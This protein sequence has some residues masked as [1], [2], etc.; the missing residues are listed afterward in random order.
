MNFEIFIAKRIISSKSGGKSGAQAL[1]NISVAAI[2]LSLSVMII[3]ISVLTGFKREIKEKLSGFGS[4]IQISNLD[5]NNSYE[6]EP[7][8]RSDE[9]V[10]KI[11]QL[12][13]VINIHAF[14]TKPGIIKSGKE[15]QGIVLKGVEDLA[16]LEFYASNLVA[17]RL[18]RL[19][20]PDSL[21]VLVSQSLA[22]LLRLEPGMKLP[23]YFVQEPLRM[24]PF[25]ISGIYNTGLEEYDRLFVLCHQAH[26]QEINNWTENQVSGYEIRIKK[27][28]QADRTAQTIQEIADG[29]TIKAENLVQVR[30]IRQLAPGFFDFL[31]LTDTNVWVILTLMTLIAGFNMVSGLLIIILD[32]VRMIGTL[33][34]LGTNNQS[35][36]KIFLYQAAYITGKGMLI[37][38]IIGIGIALL[39]M[40]L[41]VIPLD[42]ESYFVNSVPIFINPLHIILINLG[43]MLLTILMLLIPSGMISRISPDK[44]LKFD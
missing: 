20:Q 17:G 14:S 28:L 42:P 12:N 26:I 18:P 3:A 25:I 16:S 21:D 22:N 15:L 6:T 44:T 23:T 2:A 29:I 31:S 35:M 7:I 27:P 38:N 11:A 40:H 34:A 13:E 36:V 4:H 19:D 43:T 8:F 10:G 24:R 33:K 32:R 1:V 5:T 9:L 41:K 30:T 39:Q 37:G